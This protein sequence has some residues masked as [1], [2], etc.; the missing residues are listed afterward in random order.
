MELRNE[1]FGDNEHLPRMVR[2][3]RKEN[4]L[5]MQAEL[6]LSNAN[7]PIADLKPI[8]RALGNKS[9]LRKNERAVASWLITNTCWPDEVRNELSRSLSRLIDATTAKTPDRVAIRWMVRSMIFSGSC[10]L[11][12]PMLSPVR[13]PNVGV[14]Q[15]WP[16]FIGTSSVLI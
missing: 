3:L 6:V 1:Q 2:S 4:P 14:L 5:R 11:L 13:H 12:Y 9:T 16:Y 15:L 7:T 10:L 8:L